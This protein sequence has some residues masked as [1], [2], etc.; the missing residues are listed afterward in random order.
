[1]SP[2]CNNDVG[3]APREFRHVAT[4]ASDI[5]RR[6][7]PVDAQV[8]PVGPTQRLQALPKRRGARLSFRIILRIVHQHCDP[9]H[10]VRLL[11]ACRNGPGGRTAEKSDEL[12]PPHSRTSLARATN[13]SDKETPSD[14]AVFRLTAM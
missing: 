6:P 10:P 3:R 12:S 4:N 5:A 8:L 9:A 13:A 1:H 14:A 2:V 11:R 7:M